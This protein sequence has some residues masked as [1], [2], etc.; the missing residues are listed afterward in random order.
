[1]YQSDHCAPNCSNGK[2]EQYAAA[3]RPAPILALVAED[4]AA[5][6]RDGVPPVESEREGGGPGVGEVTDDTPT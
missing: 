3:S 1:M 2:A 5:W 6:D 4:G